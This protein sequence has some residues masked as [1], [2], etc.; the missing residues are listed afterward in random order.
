MERAAFRELHITGKVPR[1]VDPKSGPA[2]N[3]AAITA[4]VLARLKAVSEGRMSKSPPLPSIDSD[5]TPVP[6]PRL[7]L[8]K[9][10]PLEPMSD[11]AVE[12][13][14]RI[15]GGKWGAST[16]LYVPEAAI[17]PTPLISLR[18]YIPEYLDRE[19]HMKSAERRVT[20]T[21]LLLEALKTAG[22]HVDDIDMVEDRR[23][24]RQRGKV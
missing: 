24:T 13:N 17:P 10:K 6:R 23:K 7:D 20:K 16:Q 18:G 22:Y 3:I 19:L 14:S 2:L 1:Q 15:I 9:L 4:E 21:Y 11:E 12:E 5:L 8:K